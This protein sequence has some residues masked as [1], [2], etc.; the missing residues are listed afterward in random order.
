VRPDGCEETPG[1]H[2]GDGDAR[3]DLLEEAGSPRPRKAKRTTW[4][5]SAFTADLKPLR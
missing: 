2:E 5:L 4:R 3:A 1:G